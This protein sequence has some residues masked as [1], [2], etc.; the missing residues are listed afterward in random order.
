M[1]EAYI[2]DLFDRSPRK[3]RNWQRPLYVWTF[4]GAQI[5]PS[6]DAMRQHEMLLA[7]TLSKLTDA[8]AK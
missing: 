4:C 6:D 2:L 3:A 8:E 1:R 7:D 5:P